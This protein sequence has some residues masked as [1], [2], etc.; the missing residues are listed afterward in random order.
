MGLSCGK[1]AHYQELRCQHPESHVCHDQSL[2][3]GDGILSE[4][5]RSWRQPARH[6]FQSGLALGQ[7]RLE[8]VSELVVDDRGVGDTATELGNVL[9][10]CAQSCC[11]D[12]QLLLECLVGDCPCRKQFL[13][14]GAG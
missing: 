12:R 4:S 1:H 14:L 8:N 13:D 10:E 11:Q 2:V 3:A 9:A 7:C 6:R 5:P